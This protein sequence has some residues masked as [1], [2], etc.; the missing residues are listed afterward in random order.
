MKRILT[1]I[2]LLIVA[3]GC[4]STNDM[5]DEER[6][7][8]YQGRLDEARI[9]VEASRPVADAYVKAGKIKKEDV[10]LVY[11][12]LAAVLPA[13]EVA[14]NKGDALAMAEARADVMAQLAVLAILIAE[15]D[16]HE[17]G[18]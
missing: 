17:P 8:F 14:I 15:R 7:D 5:T 2:A 4:P 16:A 12:T 6:R 3:G 9:Y 11:A 1:L 18:E 13:F 10:D